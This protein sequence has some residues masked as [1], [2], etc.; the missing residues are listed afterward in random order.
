MIGQV[1]DVSFDSFKLNEK[2][3]IYYDSNYN[4]VDERSAE[5]YRELILKNKNTP[6]SK[7]SE[8]DIEG[9]KLK[10][11]YSNY[12]GSNNGR[13][14]I[15]LNGPQTFFHKNGY[16]SLIQYFKNNVQTAE[17]IK[18]YENGKVHVESNYLMGK[19]HD[20]EIEFYENGN[21]KS[22][23]N[24]LDGN[25]EG[26]ELGYYENGILSYKRNYS[27]N[28]PIGKEDGYYGTGEILYE[29]TYLDLNYSEIGYSKN[30]CKN[31]E[32]VSQGQKNF[33]VQYFQSSN[34]FFDINQSKVITECS[35]KIESE[36]SIINN[37]IHGTYIVYYSTGVKKYTINYKNGLKEGQFRSFYDDGSVRSSVK[38]ESDLK[39]GIE[40]GFY[41]NNT[42]KYTKNYKLGLLNG[43]E[44]HFDKNGNEV[45]KKNWIDNYIV[46][47]SEVFYSNGNLKS[48]IN[49]SNKGLKDGDYFEYYPSGNIS[50][51]GKYIRGVKETEILY[52]FDSP[53]NKINR[54]TNLKDNIKHGEEIVYYSN[55]FKRSESNYQNG[56]LKGEYSEYSELNNEM[57]YSVNY[58]DD[59]KFG[60]EIEYYSS[61]LPSKI[62]NYVDGV[63]SGDVIEFYESGAIKS[64]AE[65]N[66]GVQSGKKIQYYETGEKYYEVN[67]KDSKRM[68]AELGYYRSG[69]KLYE[70]KYIEKIIRM[71]GDEIILY[72]AKTLDE[73]YY[74]TGEKKYEKFI[75]V[76]QKIA[77]HTNY[78]KNGKTSSF[79]E[80]DG[81][82][83]ISEIGYYETDI[84]SLLHGQKLFERK[85]VDGLIQGEEITYHKSGEIKSTVIYEAGKKQGLQVYYDEYG[86]D[87]SILWEN[88]I[89]KERRIALVIGNANYEEGDE[90]LN[91]VNDARLMKESLEKLDFKVY[92]HY[93]LTS[94][95]SMNAA[96]NEFG[97]KREDY[98]V[99]FIYYAGHGVQLDNKNYLLP[100]KEEF[101]NEF[102]VQDKAIP[103]Q[104]ILRFLESGRNDQ[105]NFIVLDACRNNPFEKKWN[106]R[107]RNLGSS[108]GLAP[109]E[110]L[111]G[112]LIAYSTT[113]GQVAADGDDGNSLYTQ[114]LASRML[115]QDVAIKQVFQNVRNDVIELSNEK[116]FFQRPIEESLLTGGV[117]YLNKS[118]E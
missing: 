86:E 118:S 116:G 38:Y 66:N 79:F 103:M 70:K 71:K 106:R 23:R 4:L 108:S 68:G 25:I 6:M 43:F 8:F 30:G 9:N 114:V 80:F 83:P 2:I 52:Y 63:L 12:I 61:C 15:I 75:D 21:V 37:L 45:S 34:P 31:Y 35:E 48:I 117:Y 102:D 60:E 29:R 19:K 101:N 78:Y 20:K 107:T 65:F 28:V 96:I 110:P 54:K 47:K 98:D 13:D 14:S 74:I 24:Y 3:R 39:S 87:Y 89:K 17:E 99:A 81:L 97:L 85:Y 1:A 49:Y 104:N 44:I 57:I 58:I 41:K 77:N 67:Y 105:L 27:N 76:T 32:K 90:L 64:L 88:D 51:R 50:L 92:Y 16:Y 62:S 5:I 94:R 26:E 111:T 82:N 36:F 112:S 115:E 33:K 7:I 56:K 91:P 84:D 109:M 73:G 10:T 72:E 95:D 18:F 11:F 22:T 46:G 69:E 42:K 59:L 55:G 53:E 93:N 40:T 113:A 100:T